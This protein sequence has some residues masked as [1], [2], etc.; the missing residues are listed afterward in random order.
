MNSTILPQTIEKVF[1]KIENAVIFNPVKTRKLSFY[2][3]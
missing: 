1:K 2:F 3:I